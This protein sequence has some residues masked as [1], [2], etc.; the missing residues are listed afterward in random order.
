MSGAVDYRIFSPMIVS[1][2]PR[3]KKR[4][5]QYLDRAHA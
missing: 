2:V 1:A 5:L 4:G 3:L